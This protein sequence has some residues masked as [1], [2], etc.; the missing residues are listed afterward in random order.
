M[1]QSLI[2]HNYNYANSNHKIGKINQEN[3]Y[4]NY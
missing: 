1:T 2:K 3:Q 4:K